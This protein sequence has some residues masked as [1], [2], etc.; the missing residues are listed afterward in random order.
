MGAIDNV[1]EVAKLVKELGNM[2][3]YRQILDL[4][5][6]IMELTQ[7]NRE[8]RENMQ[9]LEDKLSQ[10]EKMTF[11]SPFY[12]TEGDDVPYCQRC[13]EVHKKAVHFPT[14]VP[15]NSGPMY[16]CPECNFRIYHPRKKPGQ[17]R[18]INSPP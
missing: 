7:A 9:K 8:L 10:V 5:G 1:K 16:T 18:A 14:P 17:Q 12:Y 11:R 13:W 6:E 3:L 4:Q 15:T 2:E